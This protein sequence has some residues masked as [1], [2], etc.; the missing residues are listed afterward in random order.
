MSAH[1]SDTE[2]ISASLL[3]ITGTV[4]SDVFS[5]VFQIECYAVVT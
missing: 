2:D 5:C 4:C 1:G 3:V